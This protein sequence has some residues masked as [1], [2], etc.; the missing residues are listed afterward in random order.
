MRYVSLLALA[1]AAAVAGVWVGEDEMLPS[2]I[3]STLHLDS[4]LAI[5][6]VPVIVL[7]FVSV[8]G[9]AMFWKRGI[10]SALA[11]ALLLGASLTGGYLFGGHELNRA[12]GECPGAIDRLRSDLTKYHQRTGRYPI[13]LAELGPVPC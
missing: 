8:L 11:A 4:P 3:S 1:I 5:L 13:N 9:G 10:F 2:R 12:L 7:A 6:A